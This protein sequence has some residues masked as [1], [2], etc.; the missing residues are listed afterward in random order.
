[1]NQE[2][3]TLADFFALPADLRQLLLDFSVQ[4]KDDINE[5]GS[6]AEESLARI[7]S[8]IQSCWNENQKDQEEREDWSVEEEVA[9]EI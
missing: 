4:E 3:K 8:R 6:N 7:T 2:L 1:M 9:A 5:L